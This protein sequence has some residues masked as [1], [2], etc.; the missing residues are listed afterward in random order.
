MPSVPIS[1]KKLVIQAN[2]VFFPKRSFGCSLLQPDTD[3]IVCI[4]IVL[5][6]LSKPIE[7]IKHSAFFALLKLKIG[8][9]LMLSA[10]DAS[11]IQSVLDKL[12]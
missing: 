9:K 11:K 10:Q 1:M 2:T 3:K 7:A 4:I 6:F 12:G 5:V 8:G